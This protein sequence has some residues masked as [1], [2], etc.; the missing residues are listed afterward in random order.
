MQYLFDTHTFIWM[1]EGEKQLSETASEII[2]VVLDTYL[3]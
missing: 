3:V 1:M 2:K